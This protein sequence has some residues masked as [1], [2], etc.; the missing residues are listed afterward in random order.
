MTI[1]PESVPVAERL[2][3]KAVIARELTDPL[4]RHGFRRTGDR[5]EREARARRAVFVG[6]LASFA[7]ALAIMPA[8]RAGRRAPAPQP[9]PTYP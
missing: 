9:R 2:A 3:R 8:R 1:D 6:A 7:A 5:L 4:G